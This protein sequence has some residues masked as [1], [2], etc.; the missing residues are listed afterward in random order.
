[1]RRLAVIRSAC[2]A[3][4]GRGQCAAAGCGGVAAQRRAAGS[5]TLDLAAVEK[6]RGAAAGASASMLWAA[7]EDIHDETLYEEYVQ[8]NS[9]IFAPFASKFRV[10]ARAYTRDLRFRQLAAPA[11]RSPVARM[12]LVLSSGDAVLRWLLAEEYLDPSSGNVHRRH[13]SSR[14]TQLYALVSSAPEGAAAAEAAAEAGTAMLAQGGVLLLA[15]YYG[16]AALD[17]RGKID[18][19]CRDHQGRLLV[20]TGAPAVSGGGEWRAELHQLE[21]EPAAAVEIWA[22]PDWGAAERL[23]EAQAIRCAAAECRVRVSA[24]SK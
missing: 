18:S 7:V 5:H 20:Q 12:P 6:L 22:L 10:L 1:M 24:F 11:G 16:E 14:H 9:R 23:G 4:A 21:G 13:R 15:E 17:W 8:T 2:G 3:A 19:A